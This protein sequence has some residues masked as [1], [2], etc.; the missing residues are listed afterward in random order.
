MPNRLS[1]PR[2]ERVHRVKAATAMTASFPVLGA[3]I[4]A[5]TFTLEHLEAVFRL[6]SPRVTAALVEAQ[7]QVDRHRHQHD[8]YG[9]R[10]PFTSHW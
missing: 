1:R 10:T 9:V 7:E 5:G 4:E 2:V 8:V 6:G 3:A